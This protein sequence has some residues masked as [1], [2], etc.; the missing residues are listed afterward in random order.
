LTELLVVIAI[1]AVLAGLVLTALPMA[2]RKARN[3]D[4]RSHLKQHGLAILGFLGD[5]N[6][7]PVVYDNG[8]VNGDPCLF[9]ALTR[10]LGRMPT[11]A[12]V[13][14]GQVRSVWSCPAGVREKLPPDY[15]KEA[16]RPGRSYSYN[17]AGLG[18]DP[19]LP[20]PPLLGLG[21]T[22]VKDG[23]IS[24]PPVNESAVVA[25]SRM[26][27]MGDDVAGLNGVLLDAT[28][29]L[30]RRAVT[31]FYGSTERVK[32]RHADKLNIL[33][34]DGRVEAL[35]LESLFSDTGDE[36]LSLW[37]RDHQPHRELLP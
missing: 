33:F 3:I 6:A 7:Y 5:Y 35:K 8:D 20:R 22:Q 25:P 36:A 34:C 4:C 37:N 12:A 15:P 17:V 10:S 29:A 31:D 23:W 30:A 21:G 16:G 2:M 13:Y 11:G 28:G 32:T 19:L 14:K 18:Q 26:I 1:V 24:S 27:C 9:G